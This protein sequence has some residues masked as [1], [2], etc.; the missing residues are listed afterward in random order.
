M[1]TLDADDAPLEWRGVRSASD[2]VQFVEYRRHA[3]D[4]SELARETL[5][6]VPDQLLRYMRRNGIDPGG[7][8]RR[9][10]SMVDDVTSAT[11]ASSHVS[12]LAPDLNVTDAAEPASPER[13]TPGPE[14]NNTTSSP[15][16][17]KFNSPEI[18]VGRQVL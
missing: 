18:V 14:H 17:P 5:E 13:P 11:S 9:S 10:V 8:V 4:T 16:K 7:A 1:R 3:G 12:S 6:E 2:I 15:M